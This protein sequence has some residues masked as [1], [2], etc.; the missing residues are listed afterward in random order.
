MGHQEPQESGAGSVP[1]DERE[2]LETLDPKGQMDSKAH[3]ERWVMMAEMELV[4]RVPRAERENVA[5]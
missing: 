4:A 3:E 1:W 5:S 2:S